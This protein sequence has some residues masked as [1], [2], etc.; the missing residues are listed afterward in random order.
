MT[1]LTFHPADNG[2]D[3]FSASSTVLAPAA[4]SLN[5][6]AAAS[7]LFTWGALTL[8]AQP[9]YPRKIQIRLTKTSGQCAQGTLHLVGQDINGEAL[10]E[11]V[12]MV[13]SATV[14]LTS[15]YAYAHLTSATV[16]QTE[17]FFAHS[18]TISLG[19]AP[20]LALPVVSGYS[21]LT[22]NTETVA[23][24][25][26]D[27][28][29]VAR[30]TV[31]TVDTVAG[32]I[33]PTTAPNGSKHF[34][35]NFT[36]TAPSIAPELVTSLPRWVS[37]LRSPAGDLPIAVYNFVLNEYWVR[38]ELVPL[39]D[40]LIPVSRFSADQIFP[41][42]G[43][44]A[45]YGTSGRYGSMCQMNPATIGSIATEGLTAAFCSDI[46]YTDPVVDTWV[47]LDWMVGLG[48]TQDYSAYVGWSGS[49]VTGEAGSAVV[50]QTD[51]VFADGLPTGGF[52]I[53]T[54][55]V[56]ASP[57][58]VYYAL[59]G[60]DQPES[61]ATVSPADPMDTVQFANFVNGQTDHNQL[62]SYMQIIAIWPVQ[63][64]SDHAALSNL[65]K[66]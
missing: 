2:A 50:N 16:Y 9:D 36:Y 35:F 52:G 66:A 15:K 58:G 29:T 40:A 7:D 4:A 51:S 21:A 44:Q 11:Y 47:A 33:S 34:T 24:S 45:Q 39:E 41:G 43:W 60:L 14:T 3:R 57:V 38:G 32:T 55:V 22:V 26:T 28:W 17:D 18:Y 27:T 31:G 56:T 46:G 23:S 19:L 65:I 63:P 6:L 54:F 30:E 8:I 20:A 59:D 64:V 42:T 62:L 61:L 37:A 1:T 48:A 10:S 53:R 49:A 25:A 13:T 5:T 12:S